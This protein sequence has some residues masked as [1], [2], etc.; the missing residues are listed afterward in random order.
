LNIN[1]RHLQQTATLLT[2]IGKTFLV[3]VVALALVNGTFASSTPIELLQKV[4][5]FWGGKGLESL[6][7]VPAHM[8]N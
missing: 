3:L 6:N 8:V 2:A 4:I 5:E 7:I 1:E